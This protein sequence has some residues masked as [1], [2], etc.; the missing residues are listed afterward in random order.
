MYK[1]DICIMKVNKNITGIILAGGR[2]S[3]MGTDKGV[4]LINGQPMIKLIISAMQPVVDTIMIVGNHAIYDHFGYA[5]I[6]DEFEDAGPLAGIY[7]GL[8]ASTTAFNLVLSCDVPLV[9]T[10][11]LSQLVEN[12]TSDHDI[13]QLASEGRAMPLIALYKKSCEVTFLDLLNK[14]DRKLQLALTHVKCKTIDVKT[15]DEKYMLNVNTA[16][17]LNQ[18][19]HGT[20]N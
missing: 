7:S 12:A 6:P 9:T 13:I 5:R 16:D 17:Q 8:K 10:K 2:S 11:L 3:R 18:L 4:L 1:T 20:N 15:E 19:Q 14:G